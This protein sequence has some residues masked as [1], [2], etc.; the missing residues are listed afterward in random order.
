LS[1]FLGTSRRC[2]S[3]MSGTIRNRTMGRGQIPFDGSNIPRK[4]DH[5]SSPSQNLASEVGSSVSAS[6]QKQSKRDEVLLWLFLFLG[7]LYARRR[8]R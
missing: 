5:P 8:H 2:S 4:V 1:S 3:T 6:R 7:P